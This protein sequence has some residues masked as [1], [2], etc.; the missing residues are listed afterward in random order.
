MNR[1]GN[2]LLDALSPSAF[3]S[4]EGSLAPMTVAH[5]EVI[6]HDAADAG[7]YFPVDCVLS[8]VTTTKA[9]ALETAT[10]G[11]EGVCGTH[12]VFGRHVAVRWMCQVPGRVLRLSADQFHA[13]WDLDAATRLLFARY[14]E[15]SIHALTQTTACNRLHLVSERCA[16]WLLTISDRVGSPDFP[17]THE[18]LA[19]TLGVRRAGISVAASALQDAGHITYRRGRFHVADRA[20]LE[21]AACECYGIV[22]TFYNGHAS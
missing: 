9:G 11:N 17:L 12:A 18:T 13:L 5:R 15:A 22:R 16:R 4:I 7:C 21:S 14:L 10:I 6:T 3:A 1:T 2:R 19:T 8:V 20:G